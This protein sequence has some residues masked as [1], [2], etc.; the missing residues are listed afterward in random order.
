MVRDVHEF[1]SA[2]A[3]PK[4]IALSQPLWLTLSKDLQQAWLGKLNGGIGLEGDE[5]GHRIR[6]G[7]KSCE[8]SGIDDMLRV[9]IWALRRRSEDNLRILGRGGEGEVRGAE[10]QQRCGHWVEHDGQQT[11]DYREL[12]NEQ[13][14]TT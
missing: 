12:I 8:Y 10:K 5:R 13:L 3:D 14:G 6:V 9:E 2:F 11:G 4:L 1:P 7:V